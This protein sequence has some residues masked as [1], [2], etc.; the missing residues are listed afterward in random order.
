V[1]KWLLGMIALGVPLS[2]IGATY[3]NNTWLQV[4]P[5][6]LGIPLAVLALRRWPICNFSASCLAAFVLV[7]LFAA[8]WSY[9]FVPYEHWMAAAGVDAV[10]RLL[11]FERNM[12]DRLVHFL[13]GLLLVVPLTEIGQ[14][15]AG[16]TRRLAATFAVLFVLA[17]GGLY[18]IFEWALTLSL[19]PQQAGAYNGEQGDIYDAQKDM[20]IAALGAVL[21][22]PVA[23]KRF[24][25]RRDLPTTPL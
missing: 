4:G 15:H 2:A 1:Q 23:V 20:A 19:S 9:S 24:A 5:V 3:P 11:A 13:F 8:R 17:F 21:A 10:S 18:E 6:A 25:L 16:M 22:L 14:R 7:H 12:F